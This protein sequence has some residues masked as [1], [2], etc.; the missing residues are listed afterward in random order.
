MCIIH[1]W[2][3]GTIRVENESTVEK[4]V[5]SRKIFFA[6]KNMERERKT[7]HIRNGKTI[8]PHFNFSTWLHFFFFVSCGGYI[9]L[10]ILYKSTFWHT[11]YLI[12]FITSIFLKKHFHRFAIYFFFFITSNAD[13][14]YSD[15]YYTCRDILKKY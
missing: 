7:C 10:A 9:Y 13:S 2:C 15:V 5:I 12:D 6:K 11:S 14:I 4:N 3:G 1:L 8:W